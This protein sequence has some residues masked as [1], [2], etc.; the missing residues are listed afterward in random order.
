MQQNSDEWHRWRG[1]GIGASDSP[2]ILGLSPWKT[3]I[4]LWEQKVGVA[5]RDEGNYATIKGHLM[6]GIAREHYFVKTLIDAQ[7]KN[8]E[9]PDPKLKYLRA[10]LD[11]WNE[12]MK[13]VLEIKCPG[14]VAQAEAEAGRVPPHYWYQM[15]HQMLVTGAEL[16]HYWS[17]DGEKGVLIE[18]DRDPKAIKEILNATEKF[19]ELITKQKPPELTDKDYKAITSKSMLALIYLWSVHKA[20]LD[21]EN[22]RL[23]TLKSEI[24]LRMD[25]PRMHCDGLKIYSAFRKGAV[26]YK[27]I[28]ELK[29]VDLEKYRKKGSASVTFR[30][31]ASKK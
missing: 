8:F 12:E 21:K 3:R 1:K 5:P 30:S 22:V 11:G 24:V 13:L 28:P 4:E 29:G 25:H 7:P 31:E 18:V 2:I 19:W 23:D 20:K 10:S 14:K 17:F 16:A 6:E 9:H 15:Q 26:D 27:K